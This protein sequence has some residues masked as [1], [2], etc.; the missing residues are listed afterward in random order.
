MQLRWESDTTAGPGTWTHT[1]SKGKP[2]NRWEPSALTKLSFFLY[3]FHSLRALFVWKS[4]TVYFSNTGLICFDQPAKMIRG[5]LSVLLVLV[6][7]TSTMGKPEKSSDKPLVKREKRIP[8]T[9]SRGECGQLRH[10]NALLRMLTVDALFCLYLLYSFS[11]ASFYEARITWTQTATKLCASLW[12]HCFS[13]S[14]W[15]DQLIWA[16]TYEEALFLARSQ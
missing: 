9:L 16:Q 14:G 1:Y 2:E 4:D 10:S 6:V 3:C 11:I 5:L 12:L 8:Q 13:F 7:V 15:G